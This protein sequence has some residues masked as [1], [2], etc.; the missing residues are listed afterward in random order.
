MATLITT[1]DALHEVTPDNG[2][3]FTLEEL[4]ALIGCEMVEALYLP[5]GRTMWIDEEGKLSSPPRPKN[6]HATRLARLAG[7]ADDDYIAGT[8]L[9]CAEGE[10]L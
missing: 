1:H 6:Y 3:D 7:I 8:A 5:D 10:V 2:T 9:V 4:Y